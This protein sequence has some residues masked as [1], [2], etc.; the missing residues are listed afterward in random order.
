MSAIYAYKPVV[1]SRLSVTI[2]WYK[3]DNYIALRKDSDLRHFSW[4]LA[5]E[6]NIGTLSSVSGKVC[7]SLQMGVDSTWAVLDFLLP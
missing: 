1:E 6:I 3:L 5:S 4:H 2:T 7:C